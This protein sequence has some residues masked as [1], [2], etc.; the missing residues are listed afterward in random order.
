MVD[1][2]HREGD[3][4]GTLAGLLAAVGIATAAGEPRTGAVLLGAVRANA[5]LVGYDPLRMDPVDGR[6]YV[7]A[8]RAALDEH[9]HAAGLVEGSRL[10]L[11]AACAV[12]ARLA[13]E[14][15][16]TSRAG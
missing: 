16:A 3:A 6:R 9:A 12:V 8:T 14:A 15:R 7:E 13:E 4:T 2:T 1:L 11:G 5:R 10:D